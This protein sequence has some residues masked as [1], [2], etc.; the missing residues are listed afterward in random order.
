[1]WPQGSLTPE[2]S[3]YEFCDPEPP[4]PP[5]FEYSYLASCEVFTHLDSPPYWFL[6]LYC[7]SISPCLHVEYMLPSRPLPLGLS[8]RLPLAHTHH[9]SSCLKILHVYLKV[10]LIWR[11]LSARL[12]SSPYLLGTLSISL[13]GGVTA[14]RCH[15]LCSVWCYVGSTW[16][17]AW[18]VGARLLSRSQLE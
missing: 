12:L 6:P 11:P 1:M 2:Y 18:S 14:M 9:V 4:P 15:L 10:I 13:C 17:C 16:L 8:W 3:C 5:P 7:R